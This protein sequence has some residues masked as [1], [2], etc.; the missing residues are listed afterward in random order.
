M[1]I[2]KKF[3]NFFL[4][5]FNLK[6]IKIV[7]QFSNAYRLVLSLK[8]NE[9]DFIFDIGANEGQFI[10]ELRY[11][12]YKD[13]VLSFEPYLEAHS[14]LMLNSAKD[15]KWNVYKPIAIGNKNSSNFMNISKN[16]VS[17][18]ILKIKK[19][20]IDNAPESEIVNQQSIIEKKLENIFNELDLNL[21]NKKLFL[22]IDTQ[23]YEFEVLKGAE[24]IL[25]QFKGVLVE[26]SLVELYEGQKNWLQIV[27]FMRTN[28]FHLW[29]VDR[30]FSNKKNGQ[31][32]QLDLCF[33]R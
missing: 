7:D 1:N 27:E 10:K 24:R 16:S 28:G 2:I 17:S 14:R 3:L 31:T 12:G 21:N 11:Y 5:I 33:F 26:V 32:L 23:G 18:S 15:K 6:L 13:D 9:I 4:K 19:E 8:E 20:H 22:K 30:G 29:S 25:T